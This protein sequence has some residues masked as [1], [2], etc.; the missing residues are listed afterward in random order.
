MASGAGSEAVAADPEEDTDASTKV[1]SSQDFTDDA[2]S[3][4]ESRKPATRGWWP[5]RGGVKRWCQAHSLRRGDAGTTFTHLGR[6]IDL[7]ERPTRPGP[8]R[9]AATLRCRVT[10]GCD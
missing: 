8:S 9:I 2:P 5:S 1:E 10:V 6:L 7:R 3:L 4:V